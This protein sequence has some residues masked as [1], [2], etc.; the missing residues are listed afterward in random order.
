MKKIILVATFVFTAIVGV[1][2]Q[3]QETQQ[4]LLNVEKLAQLKQI[5]SDLKKGYKVVSKGY[6]TI[7]NLSEGNF[8]LHKTFLDA[9]M[10]VSP[11]VR[12]YRKVADI[13]DYQLILVKEYK[14]AYG[15]FQ[16]SGQFNKEELKYLYRVYEDLIDQSLKNVEA[17]TMVVTAGKVRMSDSE[18]INAI[19]DIYNDMQDKLNFLRHFNNNTLLLAKQRQ[20][21]NNEVGTVRNIYGLKN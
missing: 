10:E 7:K 16:H 4:L 6:N 19:D 14:S 11:A 18:R 8:E 21:T 2:A 17:L 3:S 5:L 13:I 1:K 20:K 12:K 9:L 15:S